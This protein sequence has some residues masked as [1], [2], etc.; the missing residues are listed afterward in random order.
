M[1]NRWLRRGIKIAMIATVACAVLGF[2]V[3]GLWN[4]LAPPVFGAHTI[5]FWQALGLLILGRILFGGFHGRPGRHMHWRRRMMDRWEKMTPEE[6]EKFRQ[7][8]HGGCGWRGMAQG[9]PKVAAE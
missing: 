4:W 3:M 7:G 9:E 8:W 5:T 1:R 2:V 6:R